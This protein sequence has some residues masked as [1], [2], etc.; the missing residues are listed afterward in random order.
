MKAGTCN[1]NYNDEYNGNSNFNSYDNG[2]VCRGFLF[3]SFPA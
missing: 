3:R 2:E 1:Y